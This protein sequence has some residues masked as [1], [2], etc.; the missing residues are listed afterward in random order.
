MP[1]KLIIDKDILRGTSTSKLERFV[2]NHFLILPQVL[3]YECATTDEKREELLDRFRS[4]ILTGGYI[5]P[6]CKCIVQW[7]AQ[8]L[9]PY[10]SL[11]D[12][13]EAAAVKKTFEVNSRP[14]SPEHV[15]KLLSEELEFA[16]SVRNNTESFNEKLLSED[17]GLLSE[18]RKW[19]GRKNA[20]LSLFRRWAG[21][22]DSQN[23]NEWA[24]MILPISH[25]PEKYCLSREWV[26]WHFL[27][28]VGILLFLERYFLR[29]K[30]GS[31][32]VTNLEHDLQDMKYVV[33]LS[34][35][36]G[37]LTR[38]ERLAKPLAKAAFPDKDVF[39]SLEEV[40]ED[41]KYDWA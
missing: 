22:V 15:E 21:L 5:C 14:Y 2:E 19:N 9:S 28:M 7:E 33:L 26:S 17:P 1:K 11:V 24:K 37:L 34:R 3:Y 25:N 18:V 27:R 10:G 31:G 41:Y 29:H 13:E 16:G 39:S 30:G 40:P 4:L 8:N 32:S 20:K 36:D 35:A 6:T 23:M 38:D 12:L